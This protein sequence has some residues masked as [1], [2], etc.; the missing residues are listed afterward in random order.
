[1]STL[2]LSGV[3]DILLITNPQDLSLFAELL[4]DGSSLGVSIRYAVQH[5]PKGI[6]QAFLIAK[7]FIAGQPVALHLGDNVFYGQGFH[8][9][10]TEAA[11]HVEGARVFAYRVQNPKAFGVVELDA[12]N[13]VLSLEE[14]PSEPKS[15]FAVVGLYFYD[16]HV[17][18]IAESVPLSDRGEYEITAVNQAYLEQGQLCCTRM[19]RGF[20][21]LDTGSH[22]SLIHAANFVETLERRQG[23]KIACLE[24]IA[25]IKGFISTSQLEQLGQQLP[26][27]YGAYLQVRAREIA[28]GAA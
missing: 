20:A 5:E 7:E 1:M 2:L 19:G 9:L 12:D 17:V 27:E 21:W 23:L 14:K 10:L 26:T 24:E 3:D 18:E 22:Q 16:E 11:S 28:E 6:A 13:R 15:N 8:G 4:G 25:C